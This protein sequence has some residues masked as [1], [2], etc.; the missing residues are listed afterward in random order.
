MATDPVLFRDSHGCRRFDGKRVVVTAG[1]AGIGLAICHRL[2][3]EGCE[4][5]ILCSRKQNNVDEA[6]NELELKYGKGRVFGRACNVT[7]P[8]ALEEFCSEVARVFENRVDCVVS[9]V[10]VNPNAG[11]S[12][13]LNDNNY[14]KLFDANVKSHWKLI[15][16]LYPLLT[17]PGASI[18]LVRF[19]L[20]PRKIH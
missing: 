1:T 5:L 10:G 20:S 15:K 7:K 12:L 18:V 9:N 17:K 3:S 2:L 16:L 11:N 13:D 19:L 6:V 4:K 8:G 14:D